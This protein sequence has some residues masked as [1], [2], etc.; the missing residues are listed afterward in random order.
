VDPLEV[1]TIEGYKVDF[2]FLLQEMDYSLIRLI[3]KALS[4]EGSF[5]INFIINFLDRLKFRFLNMIRQ[6][7]LFYLFNSAI[8][9]LNCHIRHPHC[10]VQA[11]A[12]LCSAANVQQHCFQ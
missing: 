3:Y 10:G 6:P 12:A 7:F 9:R 2:M 11:A 8:L 5:L 1:D 4:E